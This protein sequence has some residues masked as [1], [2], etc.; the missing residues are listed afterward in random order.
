[1]NKKSPIHIEFNLKIH[2]PGIVLE[3]VY[4]LFLL[5]CGLDYLP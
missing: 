1:M 4:T 2:Y 5:A 3:V